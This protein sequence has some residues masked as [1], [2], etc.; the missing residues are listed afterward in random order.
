MSG[1][2][3]ILILV[4]IVLGIFFIPRITAR[5]APRRAMRPALGR[6]PGL[7]SGRIRLAIVASAL[8]PLAAAAW[9]RPWEGD[10]VPFLYLGAGPVAAA[11]SIAWV[12][13]GYT[14]K[15]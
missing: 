6:R 7:F 15:R 9:L 11:W 3:E 10:W 13:R 12:T 14:R 1:I 4:L 2:Q 5:N 8:W